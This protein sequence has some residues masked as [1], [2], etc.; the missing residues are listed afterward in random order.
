[1]HNHHP[2][3]KPHEPLLVD[4][5]SGAMLAALGKHVFGSKG[6]CLPKAA[7]M[8]PIIPVPNVPIGAVALQVS[9]IPSPPI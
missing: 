3:G 5:L 7:S 1:C 4:H 8:A 6:T 2:P 9:S